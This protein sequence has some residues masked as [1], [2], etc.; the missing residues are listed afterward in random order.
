MEC[1]RVHSKA[2][3]YIGYD[4]ATATF[5]IGFKSGHAYRYEAVPPALFLAFF[6]AESAGW[7]FNKAI[8]GKFRCHDVNWTMPVP[9][10][11]TP[12]PIVTDDPGD[13]SGSEAPPP[14][15]GT[16]LAG[17]SGPPVNRLPEVLPPD[18]APPPTTKAMGDPREGPESPHRP[19]RPREGGRDPP[20]PAAPGSS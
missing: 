8:K 6:K 9:P 5:E 10:S 11:P 2:I 15:P 19:G 16:D 13:R 12:P 4:A 7:H 18:R 1:E 20:P 17:A 3:A 14:H